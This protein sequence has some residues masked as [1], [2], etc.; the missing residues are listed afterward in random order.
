MTGGCHLDTLCSLLYHTDYRAIFLSLLI[1]C[2][3][4]VPHVHC[5]YLVC[6]FK[7][8]VQMP[9]CCTVA[10]LVTKEARLVLIVVDLKKSD[11]RRK[12]N[13]ASHGLLRRIINDWYYSS[14]MTYYVLY[15]VV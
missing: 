6:T 15:Y 12:K 11:G 7:K 4:H 3:A 14:K 8:F 2:D 1:W 9:K 10:F 13:L 5:T